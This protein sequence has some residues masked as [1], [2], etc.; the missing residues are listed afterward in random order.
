MNTRIKIQSGYFRAVILISIGSAFISSPSFAAPITFNTA[1]PVSE[2]EIILRQQFILT[3]FSSPN[4]KINNLTA[5]SL[6]G[7]GVTS[8][9]SVF[10]TLPVVHIESDVEGFN[11]TTFNLGDAVLFSRYEIFR[12]DQK[13]ATTRIAPL[14]GVRLPTGET[15]DSS[16]DIFGGLIATVAT[17]DFNLGGQVVYTANRDAN[18]FQT[19]DRLAFD[20]SLQC[21][22]WPQSLTADTKGF[23]FGVIEGNLTW[24]DEARRPSA[25]TQLSA[26]TTLSVSPGLQYVTQRWILDAA[27]TLPIANNISNDNE[28][29]RPNYS[30]QTSLRVNF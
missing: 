6:A 17:T 26:G 18:E 29:L 2:D 15:S 19:G 22:L 5:V 11:S 28:G 1:L 20:A 12:R 3:E 7:Y 25:Q 13:G 27:I 24:Q 9:W 10:G 21:R 4:A 8:K 23:I 16:V 14:I 30:A